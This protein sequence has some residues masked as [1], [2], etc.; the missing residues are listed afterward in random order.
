MKICIACGMPMNDVS[1]FAMGDATKDYCAHCARPDGSMQSF[2]EKKESLT[3][4]MIRT[5]GFD[6][7]AVLEVVEGM[8]KKLP[9]WQ[10]YFV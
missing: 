2:E 4:F 6:K 1:D 5:Q 3:D 10:S 8:M 7:N 9:A